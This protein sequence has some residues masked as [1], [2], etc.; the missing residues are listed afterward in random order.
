MGRLARRV[1]AAFL[2]LSLVPLMLAAGLST[3]QSTQVVERFLAENVGKTAEAWAVDL[4]LFLERQRKRL[5]A[6][7]E[8]EE[9][10]DD[11]LR[12]AVAGDLSLQGLMLLDAEGDLV[13]STGLPTWAADACQALRS[14]TD[15]VM[16]HAG[17]GHAHEVVVAVPRPG[18]LLCGQVSFTLHQDMLSERANSVMGGTAYIVDRSGTVVCHAF[19]DDEPH[20]GRGEALGG[21]AAEVAAAGAPWSGT[22]TTP[23][24][25]AFAAYAPAGD[26][27]WGVW[28]EVPR[29]VA[30]AP[31][32]R[33]I[34][35]V[36]GMAAILA[37]LA[38]GLAVWLVRRLIG[39]VQDIV[40]AVREVAAGQ[41]GTEIPVRGEDEV[42]ELA[43]EFNRM[44]S[45]L[46][47][48]YAE[49]DAR[50]A[51]RTRELETAREFSDLLLN[52]MQER[53]LVVDGDLNVV[54]ANEAATAAY[55]ADIVGCGCK[56]VHQRAGAGET[57]PAQ[58]VLE[59][60]QAEHEERVFDR[61]G[62]TEILAV[63]TYP[64]PGGD[65]VVEISRDVSE[66]KRIQA[67][68]MHQEKMAAL[69]TLAAGMAH[70]IGNPLASMSSE[71]EVLER[72]WDPDEARASLP[73]LRDQVRRMSKLLRELVEF[74]RRPVEEAAAFDPA[75]LLHDVARLLQHDPRG[76]GVEV[77]VDAAE[78]VEV[79]CSSRDRLM[80]VLVNLGINALDA[81]DGSGRVVYRLAAGAPGTVRLEVA[82]DGPGL[83]DEVARQVFDPFFTTKPPGE[84][85]GLGLFVSERIVQGLGGRIELE[86]SS[87]G[88]VFAVLLPDCNC[89]EIP[90]E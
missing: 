75:V 67:Q 4:D 53:I 51:Q 76:R 42:A 13:S 29:E 45:A 68:L 15:R 77:Q 27:P 63:D 7:P 58:R 2:F 31:L 3:W 33:G 22:T 37:I 55:G 32:R 1:L 5:R 25:A 54:R 10:P 71:L 65:A 11:A 87:E 72:M 34:V 35:R 24:G 85:T 12:A 39:P 59:S 84:G 88:T 30:A 36:F 56:A 62:R 44:S 9:D 50:V 43:R 69:G 28:V 21:R 23:D 74:G 81:L 66:L 70:E 47:T 6:V 57:C 80:Q 64:L 52:T 41:Y 89:Q 26:L 40:S 38:A 82:D 78:G 83:P 73:V 16:T 61:D 8:T 79:L 46:A 90:N 60:G 19:E 48:S 86:T 49:L 17:E 20:V 18:G 14:D